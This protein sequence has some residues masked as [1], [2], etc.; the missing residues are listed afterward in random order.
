[1]GQKKIVVLWVRNGGEKTNS[2]RVRE[3][4]PLLLLHSPYNINN[5]Y[6]IQ[7]CHVMVETRNCRQTPQR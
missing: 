7:H 2:Q 5:R 1:M 4:S 6:I 3:L